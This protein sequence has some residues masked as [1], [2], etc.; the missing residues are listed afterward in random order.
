MHVIRL[1][2]ILIKNNNFHYP[3]DLKAY[4]IVPS[5]SYNDLDKLCCSLYISPFKNCHKRNIICH[6]GK[7]VIQVYC[8]CHLFFILLFPQRSLVTFLCL[9]IQ[10]IENF[11]TKYHALLGKYHACQMFNS[12]CLISKY[13]QSNYSR[14]ECSI[15]FIRKPVEK[16]KDQKIIPT[17]R[18][19]STIIEKAK[20]Q[21]LAPKSK[22]LD[23]L[24]SNQCLPCTYLQ[25]PITCIAYLQRPNGRDQLLQKRLP[26]VLV[27]QW[28]NKLGNWIIEGNR[29]CCDAFHFV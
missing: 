9:V 16:S 7:V 26:K 8:Y 24:E 22:W 3:V 20:V 12:C 4:A 14:Q 2:I 17:D 23:H 15:L 21:I 28:K 10:V 5:L 6:T 11:Q 19:E 29:T 1:K 13:S 27:L 18:T 25:S